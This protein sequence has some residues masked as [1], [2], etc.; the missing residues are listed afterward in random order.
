VGRRLAVAAAPGDLVARLGGDEFAVLFVGLPAPALAVSRSQLILATLDQPMEIDGMRLVIEASAGVALAPSRGGIEELLR[1][2]DVAMYESK[3]GGQPVALY[4]RARDN[5]DVG[6]L[7]LTAELPRAVAEHEFA[8]DFQPI[9]DLGTG[10]VISTEALA[11]WHHP[12]RGDLT[13][14]RFLDSVEPSGLLRAFTAP[15][16][17]HPLAP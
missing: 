13:P 8:V 14:I 6:R 2:A 7:A 3:R 17:H 15:P 11:R 16:P 9:V 12:D 10:E 5:A 4:A 1:R